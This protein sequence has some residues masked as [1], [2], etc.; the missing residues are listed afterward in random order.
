MKMPSAV[1]AHF[2]QVPQA[3]IERST[4]D[5]PFRHLTMFDPDYLIPFYIDEVLPGDTF[6][7]NVTNFIRMTSALKVP[8]MDNLYLDTFFFF[9]PNRQLWSNWDRFMGERRPNPDSSISYTKPQ[10]VA[11][12][13]TGF[14]EGSLFDYFGVEIA[15]N[16]LSID[17]QYS[18][19]YNLIYR[20][21]FR[22]EN[23]INS[24][25]VDIDDGPDDP[26]DYV[27]RKRGK[28]HDYFTSCLPAPQKG[29]SGVTISLGT[30]NVLIQ[31]VGVAPYPQPKIRRTS[32]GNTEPNIAA[33]GTDAAGDFDDGTN[34]MMFDP[35][36]SL[37]ARLS[38]A[39]G[40]TINAL[41]LA[42]QTQKMLERDARGGTR[43]YEIIK[44]HFNVTDPGNLVLQR[45]EF[46]GGRST[47][48]DI[49]A[50]PQTSAVDD[51]PTP[52]GNLAG[53][54]LGTNVRDGFTKS[55]TEH[56]II[57]GLCMV[58]A[59]LTYQQ[60]VHKMFS[61][62]TRL[63][64]YFPALSH[65]GEQAVLTRE[66]YA[67][68]TADDDVVFGYQERHAE[69]RYG[70]SIITGQLRS[71]A[72]TSLDLWHLAQEF[73]DHPTL[74]QSFIEETMPIDRVTAVTTEPAFVMD[75]YMKNKTTR[76]M[77]MYSVPGL[78]DHF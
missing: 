76:P 35:N 75:C 60:G 7:V 20:E 66:I 26:A 64:Y 44:S 15:V 19:A 48:I 54:A 47:P 29:S 42:F 11:S 53:Y 41:R 23:L 32:T 69:Y 74:S 3:L 6:N 55:F 38:N 72:A 16:S 39:T 57:M 59:D 5:R 71:K 50:V 10:V 21:F 43:Y 28:R 63:D 68:G 36:G 31:P 24:P 14:V 58:R 1:Q 62:S 25:V 77:P 17:A 73:T 52:L 9:V 51:Q 45:P 27:L 37:E 30:S 65:I 67:D 70:R 46:L 13:S 4:M 2:S 40:P 18:R 8:I 49:T 78:I 56:G 33:L 22:D 12:A 34:D 61:R